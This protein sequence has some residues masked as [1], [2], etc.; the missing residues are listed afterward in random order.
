MQM[1]LAKSVYF[2]EIIYT[3]CKLFECN[4]SLVVNEQVSI[5]WRNGLAS[6]KCQAIQWINDDQILQRYNVQYYGTQ[7]HTLE[8]THTSLSNWSEIC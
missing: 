5:N 3:I 7:S 6:N 4:L 8:N 1:T 2:N